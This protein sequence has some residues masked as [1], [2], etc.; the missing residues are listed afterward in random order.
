MLSLFIIVSSFTVSFLVFLFFKLAIKNTQIREKGIHDKK[1]DRTKK[2]IEKATNMLKA[3]PNEIR[4][5]QILNNYY[6][7]NKDP[8]NGIKYAKK[9]C[10]LV[11]K[12]PISQDID[13]LKAFLSYGFY[14]L[15]RNFNREAL[16][17]LKKAYAIKKN[18]TDVNYYLGIAFLKN[19]YYKEALHYLTKIYKF[20]KNNHQALKYIGIVLFHMEN[21][22]KAVGIFNNI[23]NYIQNDVNALLIYAKCLTQL[24]Q[25]RLALEIAD[26]LKN[27]DKMTYESLLIESEIHAKNNNLEKLE[28]NIKELIKVKPDLPKKIFLELFYKLGELYIEHENYQKATDVF[29]QVERVDSN[30]KKIN[31][32]LEFSKRLSENLSLRIY[33]KSSKEKFEKLASEIIIKLYKNKFQIRDVKTNEVTSQ[34]IDIN[35][36]LVNNQWEE[37]LIVRFVRT[38]QEILGELFLKDLISKTKENKLKGLCIAPAVF[39]TKAKQII[40]GRLIDLVEGKK[41]IQILKKVNISKYQ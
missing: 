28:E 30:Y 22:Y 25:D 15:E 24:N 18:D 38:E 27:R 3:N 19:D 33:L 20:D 10:Q 2:L 13:S 35:F 8:E 4:A 26:K 23:K 40:E 29:I 14:N 9:L 34:F 17:F 5:L 39:S 41:L 31:E 36:Q 6:Y 16:E 12:N 1:S 32:K 11:E 7:E 37:N 21:Y